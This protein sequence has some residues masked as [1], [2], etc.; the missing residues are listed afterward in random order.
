[1]DVLTFPDTPSI[2]GCC[3]D[4]GFRV[5]MYDDLIGFRIE[6]ISMRT[7]SNNPL[8]STSSINKLSMSFVRRFRS[9]INRVVFMLCCVARLSQVPY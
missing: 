1:M 3:V 9:A 5:V 2:V 4:F 7:S 8:N 6:L